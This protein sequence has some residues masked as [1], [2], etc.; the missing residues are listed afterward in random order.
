M[1]QEDPNR[2]IEW[3][4]VLRK[5]APRVKQSAEAWVAQMREEPHLIW[6]TP[7]VRYVV[8]GV[9]GLILVLGVRMATEMLT[10]A[11]S[12]LAKPAATTGDFH[13]VCTDPTCGHHFVIH[14]AFGFSKFPVKCPNCERDRGASARK[15]SSSTCRGRWVAPVH[16]ENGLACPTCGAPFE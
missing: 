15:C 2:L 12:A 8:Y 9:A 14:R 10:P 5:A 16:E 6:E 13:V 7:A 3:L 11:R 1:A 4:G